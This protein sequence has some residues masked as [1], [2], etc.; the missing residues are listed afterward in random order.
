MAKADCSDLSKLLTKIAMNIGSRDNVK[1]LD[2][3]V[4]EM[5][6]ELPEIRRETLVEAIVAATAMSKKDSDDIVK[7]L[8]AIKQEARSDKNIN[9]KISDLEEYLQTGSIP[10]KQA[11]KNTA[12]DAIVQLR[13]TRGNLAKWLINSDPVL[14]EKLNKD[15]TELN[16]K[17]ESGEIDD[18]KRKGDLHNQIQLIKNQIDDIK[19][20]I[21]LSK[22]DVAAKLRQKIYDLE[23]NLALKTLPEKQQKR[24]LDIPEEIR[25]LK[26]VKKAFESAISRSEPA[27]AEKLKKSISELEEKL[28]SGSIFPKPKQTP[29][30]T[31]LIEKLQYDKKRL[32]NEIQKGINSLKPKTILERMTEPF[33]LARSLITSLDLSAVFR[34]GGF[35]LFGHPVRASKSINPMLKAFGSERIA[36]NI[37][38]QILSRPNAPL[39]TRSK[40]YIAPIDGSSKLSKMEESFMSKWAEKIPL[41]RAS[42]RAYLTFLNKLRADS[43]DIMAAGLSKTGDVTQKEANGISNYINVATGRGSMGN[44]DQAALV[45]NTIFFAPRYSVSRFQ[46]LLGQ[47]I[48]GS[49]SAKVSKAVAMEY[50]RYLIGLGVVYALGTMA[51]GVIEP[52]SRSSDFGKIRFGSTRLDVL[53][54]MSQASVL[55]SRL[56]TGK[57][58]TEKGVRPIRGENIPYGGN[59]S[60]DIISNFLRAKLSPMIGAGVNIAT[61]K[62]VVG[63]PVT[64]LSTVKNLTIPLA[65]RDIYKVMTDQGIDKGS[66]MSLLSILGVGLQTYGKPLDTWSKDELAEELGKNTY[67]RSYKRKDG[68]TYPAGHAHQGKEEY[69]TI[70]KKQLNKAK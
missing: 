51:G 8:T 23:T 33:N 57:T 63:E 65:M 16:E 27:M 22:S 20:K 45:L 42:E 58:K 17:I 1:N 7:K 30:N 40:L 10:A 15:L 41:V 55:L 47:P 28:A 48:W 32:Q 34:Q 52:D 60:F 49:G 50:A 69:V 35:I 46:L 38:N 43:F 14:A 21:K 24:T 3:V 19:N 53:S 61:G 26:E 29:I 59:D 13:K 67:K 36:F 44:M 2:D 70:L 31:K 54:S 68:K 56:I 18:P 5:Q 12:S 4:F 62:D 25:L 37:N 11:K 66:T 39:Y 9:K 64:A 6:K